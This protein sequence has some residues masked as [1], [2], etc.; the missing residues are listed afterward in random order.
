MSRNFSSILIVLALGAALFA[1]GLAANVSHADETPATASSPT[2]NDLAFLSGG[3]SGEMFGGVGE[4][5]WSPPNGGSILAAFRLIQ[6]GKTA[7]T[8]YI[9]V[10]EEDDGVFMRFKHFNND[11]TTWEKDAPNTFKLTEVKNN[12][13]VFIAPSSEQKL[14]HLIYRLEGDTLYV[15][16]GATQDIENNTGA[17]SLKFERKH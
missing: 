13:A 5:Y 17:M 6:G 7:M 1:G 11:Y 16:V 8:E 10:L 2:I 12:R 9:L 15:K 14:G 4:E 3:W